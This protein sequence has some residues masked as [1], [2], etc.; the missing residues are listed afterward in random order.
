[1]AAPAV[2][3]R[4]IAADDTVASDLSQMLMVGFDGK[5]ADDRS[6]KQL[7]MHIGEGRVGSVFFVKANVGTRRDVTNLVSLFIGNDARLLVAIDH[8]G[9]AVQRLLEPHGFTR[10]P[11]ARKVAAELSEVEA[12]QL[13]ARAGSELAELGFN[14]NFAPVVDL[15]DPENPAIGHYGRSYSDNADIVAAYATACVDGFAT[16]GVGCTLKHFP[17]AGRSHDD[18]HIDLPDVSSTWR[19]DELRPY[20]ALIAS[21]RAGMVMLGHLRLDRIESAPIPATLSAN[22]VTSLLRNQLGFTGIAV[23]DDLDMAAVTGMASRR[24]AIIQAIVAGNDLLMV[25]NAIVVDPDFPVDAI[26]WVEAAVN[27]GI[28]GREQIHRSAERVRAYKRA[29]IG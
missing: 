16:A 13:Y 9:G 8:E 22:V 25:R 14:L 10:L 7:A 5:S 27:D 23:T 4:A 3:R 15:H 2:L 29:L 24:E 19:T 26:G 12:R 6:A 20:Q 21:G 17:G 11:R 1:M 18:S 28:V